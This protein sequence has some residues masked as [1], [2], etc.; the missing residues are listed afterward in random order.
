MSRRIERPVFT[1][2]LANV[3]ELRP[4]PGSLYVSGVSGEERSRHTQQWRAE[5]DKVCFGDV[6]SETPYEAS[7]EVEGDRWTF[8]LRG[9]RGI[10]RFL[11]E[12][13]RDV[14]YLD[15]TGLPHHV[16]VPLLR[17]IRGR[18]G[19]RY[20]VYVEPGDY[21]VSDAPTSDTIFDLSAR[22]RGI[23]PLPGLATLET[24]VRGRSIF[25]P[26]LGFEGARFTFVLN[27]VDP[28]PEAHASPH[29]AVHQITPKTSRYTRCSSSMLPN[30]SI[31]G[32]I[33]SSGQFGRW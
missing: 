4:E 10:G 30:V 15:I 26:L 9:V 19:K 16:W 23:A 12:Q 11:E 21:R 20:C 3:A 2:I 17:G 24:E 29:F 8:G 32:R 33:R 25:V 13:G 14:V 1:R 6:V 31:N 28:E 5:C 18:Q 22:I 7:V 27:A